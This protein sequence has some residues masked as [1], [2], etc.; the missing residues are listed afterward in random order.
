MVKLDIEKILN[1]SLGTLTTVAVLGALFVVANKFFGFLSYNGQSPAHLADV[2][3]KL[4]TNYEVISSV[5]GRSIWGRDYKRGILMSK[6][7]LLYYY[8]FDYING[9]PVQISIYPELFETWRAEPAL[10]DTAT[11]L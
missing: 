2:I 9:A 10:F 6:S 7:G 3:Q 11:L 1:H 8:R 4:T 5:D